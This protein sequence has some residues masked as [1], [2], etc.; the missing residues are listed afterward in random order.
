MYSR[1]KQRDW[2]SR[3]KNQLI[4]GVCL[5]PAYQTEEFR[6]RLFLLISATVADEYV[7][8]VFYGMLTKDTLTSVSI[9]FNV[10]EALLS[11]LIK[12]VKKKWDV[13]FRGWKFGPV[14]GEQQ[15]KG[16]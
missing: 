5:N 2:I 13:A 10:S 4:D 8:A 14:S 3:E 15:N 6:D 9:K 1:N 12:E 7:G 16:E 11:K